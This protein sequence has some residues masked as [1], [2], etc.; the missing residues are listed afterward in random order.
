MVLKP[1][2]SHNW[3]IEVSDISRKTRWKGDWLGQ[4][5]FIQVSKWLN[6]GEGKEGFQ[7]FKFSKFEGYTWG[8]K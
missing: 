4:I 8:P 5:H 3:S 2:K 7:I 1:G 6:L